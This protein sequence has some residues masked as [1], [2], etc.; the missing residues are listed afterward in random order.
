[1]MEQKIASIATAHP[2]EALKRF[3]AFHALPKI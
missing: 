3:P 1:M 2:D